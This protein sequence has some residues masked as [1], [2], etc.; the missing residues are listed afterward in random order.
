MAIAK[1]KICGRSEKR[2]ALEATKRAEQANATKS[3]APIRLHKATKAAAQAT[4]IDP[5][6][7]TIAAAPPIRHK[8]Q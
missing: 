2:K 4:K 3:E 1:E 7:K 6:A 8:P 5:L